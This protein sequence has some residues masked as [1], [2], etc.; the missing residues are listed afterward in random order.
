MVV[1]FM[2]LCKKLYFT[3]VGDNCILY[4]PTGCKVFRNVKKKQQHIATYLTPV[5]ATYIYFFQFI[6]AE[7]VTFNFS[8][9]E[10]T[11]FAE[12]YFHKVI[13]TPVIR[14]QRV[15]KGEL[16][17]FHLKNLINQSLNNCTGFLC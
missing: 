7:Q 13:G 4:Y 9:N 16:F 15:I 8:D 6:K 1:G 10:S 12:D 17:I 11:G 2:L 3:V 5:P 14:Q